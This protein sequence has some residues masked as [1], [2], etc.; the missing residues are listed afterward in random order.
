MIVL[1]LFLPW[2]YRTWRGI[3]ATAAW[4]RRRWT[5]F[6]ALSFW[7]L[8][9]PAVYHLVLF[10]PPVL[11]GWWTW[12]WWAWRTSSSPFLSK[13][14]HCYLS[15]SLLRSGQS[16]FLT[17]ESKVPMSFPS[18]ESALVVGLRAFGFFGLSCNLNFDSCIVDV[19][20]VHI[21]DSFLNG[22]LGIENLNRSENTMKA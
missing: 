3:A 5:S 11:G 21:I 19:F 12:I 1:F 10:F 13:L 17:I 22:I 18:T 6:S 14:N 9:F 7:F 4:G 20:S 2:G 8:Y 15:L 16:F